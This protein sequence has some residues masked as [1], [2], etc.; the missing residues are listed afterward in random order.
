M[1]SIVKKNDEI[2]EV[3]SPFVSPARKKRD[4]NMSKDEWKKK[5]R[6]EKKREQE[7]KER[8]EREPPK[9]YSMIKIKTSVGHYPVMNYL[10][11][12]TNDEIYEAKK[13]QLNRLRRPPQADRP[14]SPQAK[15]Q[16][17]HKH[18]Q[19]FSLNVQQ[20][21]VNPADSKNEEN[22]GEEEKKQINEPKTRAAGGVWLLSSD[23]PHCF[24][25]LIVYHNIQKYN[26]MK[27]VFEDRWVDPSQPYIANEKEIMIKLELDEEMMKQMQQS[28][29]SNV[30]SLDITKQSH[31]N[32]VVLDHNGALDESRIE[33]GH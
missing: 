24:Q 1:D 10:S 5:R 12:F 18:H 25:N 16:H 19:G 15:V 8:R 22:K 11:T 17:Q 21:D 29:A 3:K 6:E 33:G 14:D 9:Q 28:H 7:E 20:V 30:P 27:P 23:F 31:N 32:S 26:M 2:E 4:K 13:C